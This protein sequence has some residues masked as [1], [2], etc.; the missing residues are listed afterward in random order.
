MKP[1]ISVD[2]L[3]KRFDD[4]LVFD[5]LNLSIERGETLAVLG[6]SGCGKSTLLRCIGGLARPDGGSISV[7][8]EIG[9]VYQEPRLFPWLSVE[10]NVAFAARSDLERGRVNDAIALVGLAPAAHLLPKQ[11]SGG[12]AQ[13]ASLARALVRNPSILL[14]DE[15]LSALD[16]LL[17]LELQ[18]ALADIVRRLGATVALVTHDVDEALFLADRVLVLAGAPARIVLE[19]EVPAEQRRSRTADLTPQRIELLEALGVSGVARQPSR[20][21]PFRSIRSS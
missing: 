20:L 7:E 12:M 8:S 18:A 16:A 9:Y 14:M 19:L 3:V 13:R 5:G 4:R 10:K 21:I 2:G 1:A 11:L 15:P 6:A 17:R